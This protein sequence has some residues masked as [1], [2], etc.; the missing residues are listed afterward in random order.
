MARK[1]IM[2]SALTTEPNGRHTIS[3]VK[4]HSLPAS[5]NCP[6]NITFPTLMCIPGSSNRWPSKSW[7]LIIDSNYGN[8]AFPT[9]LPFIASYSIKIET[10][11]APP[12]PNWRKQN[13][14]SLPSQGGKNKGLQAICKVE[15]YMFCIHSPW[16]TVNI[17]KK[18]GTRIYLQNW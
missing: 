18:K 4:K 1:I 16:Q 2:I 12:N 10:Y 6:L 9:W 13:N 14:I 7:N 3:I 8:S 17:T 15:S 11:P 5:C